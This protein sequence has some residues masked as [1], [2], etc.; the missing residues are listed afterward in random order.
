MSRHFT[1]TLEHDEDEE[2]TLHHDHSID[3]EGL[4]PLN[5]W[6]KNQWIRL[7]SIEER[8]LLASRLIKYLLIQRSIVNPEMMLWGF[9]VSYLFVS[10]TIDD[11]P[12]N[13]FS[14]FLLFV[15]FKSISGLFLAYFAHLTQKAQEI[16]KIKRVC[17]LEMIDQI[18]LADDYTFFTGILVYWNMLYDVFV[19]ICLKCNATGCFHTSESSGTNTM[20]ALYYLMISYFLFIP[21]FPF[22]YYIFLLVKHGS[23]GRES[24]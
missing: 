13:S 6:M 21:I 24:S 14:F 15:L 23:H 1:H 18:N 4:F 20:F 10:P 9:C 5:V 8:P 3:E 19:L 22:F 7:F 2:D 12:M 16:S 17:S 11:L